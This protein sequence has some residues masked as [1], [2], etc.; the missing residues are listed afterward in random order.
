MQIVKTGTRAWLLPQQ[1]QND[2]E[3]RLQCAHNSRDDDRNTPVLLMVFFMK[4]RINPQIPEI[5]PD[6]STKNTLKK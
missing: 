4:K 1:Y 5:V 3:Q 6:A 2:T